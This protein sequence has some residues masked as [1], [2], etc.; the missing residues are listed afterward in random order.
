MTNKED[1]KYG[2]LLMVLIPIAIIFL[3][4]L[5]SKDPGQGHSKSRKGASSI[6]SIW[7]TEAEVASTKKDQ[8]QWDV[9]GTA[10][11]LSA[12][13]VWKDQIILNTV[14]SNDS[15]IARWDP[16]AISVGDVFQGEVSTSTVKRIA[17]IRAIKGEKFSIGLFDED[18][19]SR[20]YVGGW[21]IDTGELRTGTCELTSKGTLNRLIISVTQDDNLTVPDREFKIKGA[22]YLE[23]PNDIMLETVKRWAKEAK[24]SVEELGNN[25]G[26]KIEEI[27]K[28]VEQQRSRLEEAIKE[29]SK[30]TEDKIREMLDA[31]RN[32]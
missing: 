13:V 19:V 6:Y 26:E 25:V 29:T 20:D 16:I 24:E 4:Y 2:V 18:I 12:M 17:R 8:S 7:L 15:L 5:F 14:T 10:P 1:K 27:G 28:Q 30:K 22:T 11:D 23:E 9:D 32:K 31:L 3:G 21:E